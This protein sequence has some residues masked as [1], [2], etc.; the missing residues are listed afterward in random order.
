MK[1]AGHISLF[2]GVFISWSFYERKSHKQA[3]PIGW[4]GL[5]EWKYTPLVGDEVL[6]QKISSRF[7]AIRLQT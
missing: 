3:R 6:L 1:A 7:W 4:Q 2:G 5:Y